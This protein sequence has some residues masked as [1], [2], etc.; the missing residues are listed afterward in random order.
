MKNIPQTV[1]LPKFQN[2]NPNQ[3]DVQT[4]SAI[5]PAAWDYWQFDLET[6]LD[7]A[8]IQEIRLMVNEAPLWRVSGSDLD[9]INLYNG[10]PGFAFENVLSL[11]MRRMNV[12]MGGAQSIKDGKLQ[13]GSPKDQSLESSLNCGSYDANGRGISALSMEIDLVNTGN[14]PYTIKPSGQATDPVPGG[15]GLVRVLTKSVTPQLAGG[16]QYITKPQFAFGD[17]LHSL[18]NQLHLFPLADITLDNFVLRFNQIPVLQESDALNRFH[19]SSAI[20]Y[21]VPQAGLWTLDFSRTGAGDEMLLI[22][23]TQ[24]DLQLQMDLSDVSAMRILE[25]ALGFLS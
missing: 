1:L 19:Q 3:V 15:P 21:R 13:S 24:T 5:W 20:A 4:V 17:L 25:D 8:M 6:N 14:G 2:I 9:A 11:Y 16:T 12:I 7:L 22:A 18:L 10:Q 23:P